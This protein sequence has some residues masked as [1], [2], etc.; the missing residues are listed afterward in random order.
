VQHARKVK[1]ASLVTVGDVKE[2]W[3]LYIQLFETE[4]GQLEPLQD[5]DDL[6]NSGKAA[7]LEES[8]DLDVDGWHEMDNEK[9]NHLLQYPRGKPAFFAEIQSKRELCA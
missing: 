6:E 4:P 2:I 7:W 9:L 1:T 3:A 5:E 8:E